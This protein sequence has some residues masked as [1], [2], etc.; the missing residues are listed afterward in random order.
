[1]VR[2][3]IPCI[4]VA[5][6][7]HARFVWPAEDNALETREALDSV[8][9]RKKDSDLV[10]DRPGR[11]FESASA[12]RHAYTPR[13]D[14]HEQEK[15]KFAHLVGEK[16][17]ALEAAGAFNELVLVAPPEILEA[18]RGSL[19]RATEAKV[20]GTLAKDLVRVPDHDLQPHLKEWVRPVHR[21]Q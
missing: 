20:I 15:L 14:P 18:I 12:A 4:V 13:T 16:L 6:G 8:S 21:Q 5:D 7:G 10:S 1:M 3:R 19:D 17:S 2:H 9:A 11:A